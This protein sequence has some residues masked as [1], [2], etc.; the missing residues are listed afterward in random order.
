MKVYYDG[1]LMFNITTNRSMSMDEIFKLMDFDATEQDECGDFKYD[2]DL[3]NMVYTENL[4]SLA[5]YAE[6]HGITHDAVK[7]KCQRGGYMTARKIGRNW[8]IDEDEP[9]QDNRIKSGEYVDW[10]K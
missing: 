6:K 5:E 7:K 9:Y 4:I 10:R 1:V 3:F 2:L 8:V